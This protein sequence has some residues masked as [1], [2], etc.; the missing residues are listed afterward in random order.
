MICSIEKCRQ[1]IYK[2]FDTCFNHITCVICTEYLKTKSL[3]C[4]LVCGHAFHSE[5]IQPWKI[6]KDCCPLCRS[7]IECLNHSRHSVTVLD[8]IIS[9]QKSY[10]TDLE[11]NKQELLDEILSLKIEQASL[12]MQIN[13]Q[14]LMFYLQG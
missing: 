14:Q 13:A 12:K 11:K 4:E 7:G 3:H 9:R 6:M 5:C 10:I 2:S 1:D 8:S